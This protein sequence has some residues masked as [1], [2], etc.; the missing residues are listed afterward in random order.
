MN[1]G[2]VLAMVVA[3]ALAVVPGCKDKSAPAGGNVAPAPAGTVADLNLPPEIDPARIDPRVLNPDKALVYYTE[4]YPD[5]GT[6]RI[7]GHRGRTPEGKYDRHGPYVQY[8]KDGK[9]VEREGQY[10]FGQ[11]TGV[12]KFYDQAGNL[13]NTSNMGGG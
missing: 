11:R 12:W 4:Y 13:I 7:I 2:A 6:L 9:T 8:Y 5:T 1:R 10:T 3:M